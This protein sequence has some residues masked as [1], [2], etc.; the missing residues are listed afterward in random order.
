[1]LQTKFGSGTA[2]KLINISSIL[3]NNLARGANAPS[4]A[5]GQWGSVAKILYKIV[6]IYNI[7]TATE[8]HTAKTR[9][10]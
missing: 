5:D 9:P 1:M 4:D 8:Q 3:Y 6:Y 2:F 10:L 7:H